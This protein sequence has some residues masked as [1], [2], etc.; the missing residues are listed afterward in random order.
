MLL[1]RYAFF[2]RANS[3]II[4]RIPY[5]HFDNTILKYSTCPS[6][7]EEFTISCRFCC[8][9][10]ILDVWSK[11]EKENVISARHLSIYGNDWRMTSLYNC[12]IKIF[13]DRHLISYI[14]KRVWVSQFFKFVLRIYRYKIRWCTRGERESKV[15]RFDAIGHLFKDSEKFILKLQKYN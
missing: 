6:Y 1:F 3:L 9:N 10:K 8:K 4:L 13:R 7:I 14:S 15:K 5:Q 12:W 11:F 2:F